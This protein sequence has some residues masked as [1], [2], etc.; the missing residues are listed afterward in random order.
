MINTRLMQSNTFRTILYF[1]QYYLCIGLATL[2]A[3]SDGKFSGD[4]HETGLYFKNIH[5]DWKP[6]DRIFDLHTI[7]IREIRFSFSDIKITHID[8]NKLETASLSLSGPNLSMKKLSLQSNVRS[9]NWITE[10]KIKRL[11]K[12]ESIPRRSIELIAKAADLYLVDHDTLPSDINVLVIKK[13]ISMDAPPLNDYTWSYSLQLPEQ[14][15]SKPT[16]L[17]LVPGRNAILYDWDS[18]SFQL[19]PENDSLYNT[20]LVD[21]KYV[22]EINEITQLF[23][24]DIHFE[25]RS[26]TLD[27]D[28]M[29]KRGQFKIA[30]CSFTAMPH[31]LLDDRSSISLPDMTLETKDIALSGIV[32][33][34]PT[35]HRG[36]GNF[37]V[38]NFEVKIPEDLKEEPEIQSI[39]ETMGIWNNSIMVRLLELEF[40]M[41]N[42]FTGDVE[43]KFHTPFI[44]ISCTGDFSIRQ[45]GDTPDIYLHNTVLK[46]HPISLGIRKWIKNW[47]KKNGRKLTREGAT[48]VLKMEGPLE[49]PLIHGY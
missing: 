28:I 46:V 29:M 15:I 18:R 47:E 8:K 42:Q 16:Q 27:F 6:P 31:D 44:K 9:S 1:F 45:D 32:D 4:I 2:F 11:K 3:Q 34:T 22:F 17:N 48:I 24:S 14:I 30:G 41:I 25:K 37:R 19:D 49:K 36:H 43:F 23:A 21:W 10:E 38:R 20:P 26:D 12:R 7:D 13:Y 33:E 39:L 35:I 40:N 5:L